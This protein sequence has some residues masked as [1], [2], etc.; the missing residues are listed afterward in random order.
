M[1]ERQCLHP[2]FLVGP[3]PRNAWRPKALCPEEKS[4]ALERRLQHCSSANTGRWVSFSSAMLSLT[5]PPAWEGGARRSRW[6]WKINSHLCPADLFHVLRISSL[7]VWL[8]YFKIPR[9]SGLQMG[10]SLTV[11]AVKRWVLHTG[12]SGLTPRKRRGLANRLPSPRE[13]LS[14]PRGEDLRLGVCASA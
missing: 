4:K 11:L 9:V 3:P 6:S 14:H 12:S 13:L 1:T 7:G 2:T 8:C 5:P 10:K